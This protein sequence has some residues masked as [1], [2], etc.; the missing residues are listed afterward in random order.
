M[1]K[2]SST[3][4]ALL[5]AFGAGAAV[6]DFDPAGA[7]AKLIEAF[8]SRQWEQL[9]PLLAEDIVFHRANAGEVYTGPKQV[10]DHFKKTIGGEWN[11]KF[12]HLD[13][14]NQFSG[15]DGRVV[16]R[17]DFAITAGADDGSCY[18][19]S[20]LMTWAPR[21]DGAWQLQMLTWQDLETE[22]ANCK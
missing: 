1:W 11:V 13:S 15:R 17:G 10:L 19:G 21:P 4:L 18:R 20:Y 6:A 7:H 2:T 8:N 16:E 9:R 3:A 12:A 14:T 5:F 22:L